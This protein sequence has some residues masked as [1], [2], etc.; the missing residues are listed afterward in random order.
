MLQWNRLAFFDKHFLLDSINKAFEFSEAFLAKEVSKVVKAPS[1]KTGSSLKK[2]YFSESKSVTSS[3][4]EVKLTAFDVNQL[5]VAN[6]SG[7]YGGE[8]FIVFG[9]IREF[10]L[11]N[12]NYL[13]FLRIYIT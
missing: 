12:I 3:I 11:T 10:T 7:M 6:I 8:A 2:G 4:K 13:Y 1:I 5:K 9:G